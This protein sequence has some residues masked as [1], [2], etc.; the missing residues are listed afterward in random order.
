MSD[1]VEKLK[2]IFFNRFEMNL[3]KCSQEDFDRALLG[4]FFNLAPRDLIYLFFDIEKEFNINIPQD[5]IVEGRFNTINNIADMI[6]KQLSI[7]ES[8]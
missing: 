5:E 3:S 7:K 2:S 8:A 6:D 4:S 1:T